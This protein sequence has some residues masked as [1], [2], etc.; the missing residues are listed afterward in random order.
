M[1]RFRLVS[2]GVGVQMGIAGPHIPALALLLGSTG[3]V[4]V[5]F[6]WHSFLLLV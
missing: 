5:S 6:K 4:V 2:I 3:L 1:G